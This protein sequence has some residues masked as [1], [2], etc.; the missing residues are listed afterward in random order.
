MSG[1][2]KPLDKL[3]LLGLLL[4]IGQNQNFTAKTRTVLAVGAREVRKEKP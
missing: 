4:T 3:L 1:F 2:D